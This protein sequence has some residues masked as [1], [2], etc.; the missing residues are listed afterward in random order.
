MLHL[1]HYVLLPYDGV[2]VRES[3]GSKPELNFGQSGSGQISVR[4]DGLIYSSVLSD[5][6]SKLFGCLTEIVQ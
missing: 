5:F 1:D 3:L 4:F 2:E 6:G